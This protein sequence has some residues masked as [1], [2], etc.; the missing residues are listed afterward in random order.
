MKNLNLILFAITISFATH[1]QQ[2]KETIKKEIN[3]PESEDAV[4]IVENI[5]GDIEVQG[6]SG[7]KVILTIESEF[8][9]DTKEE[10]EQAMKNVFLS[11]EIRDDTVDVF[12]DGICGCHR[13]NNRNYNWDQCDFNFRYDFKVRVPTRANINVSTVN[14]GEVRVESISGEVVARNVNGGITENNIS[15]P[16]NVHTVNGDVE[17]RHARNP[18][19]KSKYYSLNGDVNIFYDSSLSAEMHFK[20]FQGD[21]FTDFAISEWLAPA[22]TLNSSKNKS[23]TSYRI[24]SKTA[25][26]VGKGGVI[27]EFETFN[28]DV[29]VRKI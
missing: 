3:F 11:F 29:Y 23:G 9:A 21:M 28:G 2:H 19:K 24:E 18:S 16:T 6:Y 27:L 7:D 12:L 17:V 20:S 5:F 15:G 22:L 14:D 4:L 25:V 13:N 8:N 1:A 10:L 26:K